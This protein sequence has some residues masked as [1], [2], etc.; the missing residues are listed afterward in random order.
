MQA[1]T[2]ATTSRH[3]ATSTDED[4][5]SASALDIAMSSDSLM[6]VYDEAREI[7]Q[8]AD[9]TGIVKSF[10]VFKI[11]CLEQDKN[12]LQDHILKLEQIIIELTKHRE[13]PQASIKL[14][15]DN[16][17]KQIKRIHQSPDQA[18][19]ET[20]PLKL[21]D[22]LVQTNLGAT[23][24]NPTTPD[25]LPLHSEFTPALTKV[26]LPPLHITQSRDT[27]QIHDSSISFVYLY[28]IGQQIGSST[29]AVI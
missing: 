16:E 12:R 10:A 5:V 1:H 9:D 18:K 22:N 3:A 21:E 4:G 20:I 6:R 19:L 29:P 11:M 25:S 26:S 28:D 15:K 14:D 23:Q 13:Y 24:T 7:M 27:P 17:G 2:H 8:N